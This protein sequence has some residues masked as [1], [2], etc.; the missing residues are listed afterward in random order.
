MDLVAVELAVGRGAEVVFHV[1]RA[2]DVGRVRGAAGE[3]M[4]DRAIGL[5]H[6]VG[7]DVEAAAV[8]HADVDFLDAHL[9][10]IFDHR[11][12]RRDRA[13]AAIEAE[14]LGADIF[15]GEEFF[16]L[17]GLDDLEQDRLLAFGREL[18][19]VVGALD[20][21]LDEATLLDVVDVHIFEADMA[22]VVLLQHLDDF[23]HGR[24]LEAERPAEPDRAVEVGLVK[25]VIGGR[26][27]GRHVAAREA[28]RIELGGEMT[29]HA[30]GADQ[31]HRPDAVVGGATDVVRAGAGRRGLVGAAARTFSMVA[32]VGS[33]PR[34][35]SSSS[36]SGQFGRAQL[37][38]GSASV[39]FGSISAMRH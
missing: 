6:H 33:R 24:L 7:E 30:I 14:T 38:P 9:A 17:L 13:F 22:A 20:P 26:E 19:R 3:F 27:V 36:D 23:A 12:K 1:A 29:A 18:D 31:H 39:K 16:P 25:A 5:A 11:L 34:F 15:A 32:W 10:A 37:G 2:T 35:S 8:G 21:L 4:E 28:E